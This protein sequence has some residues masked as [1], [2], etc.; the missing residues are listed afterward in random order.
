MLNWKN[1][2]IDQLNTSELQ[3]ALMQAIQMNLSKDGFQDTSNQN[4]TF[5]LGFGAGVVIAVLGFA[6][7]AMI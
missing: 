2:P 4:F 1:K 3:T 7:G 6:I 5:A